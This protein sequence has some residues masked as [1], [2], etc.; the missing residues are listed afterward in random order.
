MG[1]VFFVIKQRMEIALIRL[2]LLLQII[3]ILLVAGRSPVC[4][5]SRYGDYLADEI[6]T[7]VSTMSGQLYTGVDNYVELDYALYK[8]ADSVVLE[9]SNGI[10]VQDTLN[11]YLVIPEKSGKLRLTL[12]CTNQVDTLAHGI[13]YFHSLTLPDP[14]LT[15]NN[16]PFTTPASIEKA[17]LLTCDSLGVF[18]SDDIIGSDHWLTIT[19]FELGYNYGGFHVSQKNH[20]NK[21]TA[22]TKIIINRLGPDHDISIKPTVIS[23][24]RITKQLP[25]YRIKIY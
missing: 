21:L 20:T 4:G 2:R 19:E 5:Q 17:L 7:C 22:E 24:G 10:A 12:I 23:N 3:P 14:L 11:R 9:T 8:S 1:L 18:F 25:I 15:I 16:I 13:K 6:L